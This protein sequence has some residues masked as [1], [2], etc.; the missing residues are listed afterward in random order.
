[1]GLGQPG[2]V[3]KPLQC[4]QELLPWLMALAG[5][6]VWK[7]N[8]ICLFSDYKVLHMQFLDA[9]VHLGVKAVDH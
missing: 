1:M 2:V 9:L 6:S 7:R 5:S 8:I 3:P 4:S